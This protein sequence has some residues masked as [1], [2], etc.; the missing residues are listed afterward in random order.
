[1]QRAW[2]KNDEPKKDSSE[3]EGG[4]ILKVT[5]QISANSAAFTVL[6]YGINIYC[7][8]ESHRTYQPYFQQQ[9]AARLSKQAQINKQHAIRRQTHLDGNKKNQR[10][11]KSISINVFKL[12]AT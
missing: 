9:W 10:S 8:V 12:S 6:D 1:M 2:G 4:C 11:S 7:V 5:Q 3:L